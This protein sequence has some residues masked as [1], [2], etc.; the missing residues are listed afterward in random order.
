[1]GRRLDKLDQ[2]KK[3]YLKSKLNINFYILNKIKLKLIAF[4]LINNKH[5]F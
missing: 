2:N 4:L 5:I 3:A 1:M